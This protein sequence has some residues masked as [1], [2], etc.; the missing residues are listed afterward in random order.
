MRHRRQLLRR[1]LGLG[2]IIRG[3]GAHASREHRR[4]LVRAGEVERAPVAALDRVARLHRLA[5]VPLAHPF[6]LLRRDLVEQPP[7]VGGTPLLQIDVLQPRQAVEVALVARG[8]LARDPLLRQRPR[9]LVRLR[10]LGP[11]AELHEDVRRHVQRV[12]RARGDRGVTLRGAEA[13]RRVQRIVVGVDEVVQRAGMIAA[14]GDDRLEQRR[15]ADA[16]ARVDF[17]APDGAEDGQGVEDARLDV[18]RMR[19]REARHRLLVR[20][21]ARGLVAFAVELC[22]GIEP[23]LLPLAAR[24]S[25]PPFHRAAAAV[26]IDLVPDRM[27]VRHRLAP[28]GEGEVRIDALGLLERALRLRVGEVVQQQDAAQEG[29]LRLGLAAVREGDRAEVFVGRERQRE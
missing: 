7:R 3:D 6:A 20:G 18:V 27:V 22:D 17:V 28:V 13:E 24:C 14:L 8:V 9:L 19:R 15:G 2:R 26:E 23:R 25:L 29:L 4:R 12:R 11:H 21:V 5:R 10:G 16:L 1:A